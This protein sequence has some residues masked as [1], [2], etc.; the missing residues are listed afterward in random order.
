MVLCMAEADTRVTLR[1]RQLHQRATWVARCVVICL[2]PFSLKQND[3]LP[4]HNVLRETLKQH[5]HGSRACCCRCGG[6]A[7]RVAVPPLHAGAQATRPGRRGCERPWLGR[8][9]DFLKVA[10]DGR[11]LSRS[12]HLR[13]I[14]CARQATAATAERSAR[15]VQ[16]P[17]IK[18]SSSK[19][20]AAH[21]TR[22]RS[23]SHVCAP[24][25]APVP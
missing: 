14:P 5:V 20:P 11:S 22:G 15:A 16:Q 18:F 23:M 2:S 8:S 4:F 6:P 7:H 13:A 10:S 24:P 19:S 21:G 25:E 12:T 17:G 3:S 9:T 1:L